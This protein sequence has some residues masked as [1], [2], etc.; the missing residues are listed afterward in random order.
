MDNDRIT[1]ELA[2]NLQFVL[3][4]SGAKNEL[5]YLTKVSKSLHLPDARVEL[6]IEV[7]DSVLSDIQDACVA[8]QKNNAAL[9]PFLE[10]LNIGLYFNFYTFNIY[11]KN[12][13]SAF[14]YLDHDISINNHLSS[15][16]DIM[17]YYY[18]SEQGLF[19]EIA[20]I[21]PDLTNPSTEAFKNWIM[22]FNKKIY[23][24]SREQCD[25]IVKQIE[26]IKKTW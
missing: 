22:K 12:L 23:R 25:L 6:G 5:S 24:T 14:P 10:N 11:H 18:S 17:I 3:E 8:M 20:P 2:N 13:S 16:D 15:G 9:H 21:Y 7:L 19:L 26:V 1:F 4:F